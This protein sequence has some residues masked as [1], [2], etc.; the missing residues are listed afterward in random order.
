MQPPHPGLH[1]STKTTSPLVEA[2]LVGVP[3]QRD[4]SSEENSGALEAGSPSAPT[5]P[6][7]ARIP[8][9]PAAMNAHT[10]PAMMNGFLRTDGASRPQAVRSTRRRSAAPGDAEDVVGVVGA[11]EQLLA[12]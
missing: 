10:T 5:G 8:R 6:R 7:Q 9:P 3:T 2:R 1:P 12:L 11:D 4:A